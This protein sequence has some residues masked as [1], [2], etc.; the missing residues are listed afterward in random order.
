[1]CLT[2]LVLPRFCEGSTVI[3]YG[4]DSVISG[5]TQNETILFNMINDMRRQGKMQLI[6]LSDKLCK[7]AHI[8]IDDLLASKPQEKGCSLHSWSASGNWSACCHTKDPSG[9]QCMKS[10][11]KEITG[12]SGNGYELIYWGEDNATPSEASALWQQ[13][14]ASADMIMCRGK[15]KGYDWKAMGVGIKNGY[16]VLWL[17]DKTD[18]KTEDLPAIASHES[19]Q[20]RGNEPVVTKPST[21]NKKSEVPEVAKKS[22]ETPLNNEPQKSVTEDANSKF[23]LIAASV[24][25][26]ESANSELKRIK[27]KGYPDAFILN[28]ESIFRIALATFEN[29]K[30]ANKALPVIRKDFP[31]AWIFKK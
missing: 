20:R 30:Q 5:I 1:M 14:D 24:K 7:V 18:V 25:T 16:A 27:S 21:T 2:V 22:I 4:N 8:H 28:G 23:Y 15:W 29:S 9:I 3:P 19:K 26:A 6:P 31:E 12:Y 17:G 10:K 11:P 13:V